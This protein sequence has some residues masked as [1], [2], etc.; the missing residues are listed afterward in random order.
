MAAD[1]LSPT[2]RTGNAAR[3][4]NVVAL[5]T[6]A[7]A[8]VRQPGGRAAGTYR[9]ANPW[10]GNDR[11]PV[12]GPSEAYQLARVE[13]D[14]AQYRYRL[15][16]A[17]S[18]RAR[19]TLPPDEAEKV[20]EEVQQFFDAYLEATAVLAETPAVTTGQL[21]SKVSTIGRIWLN[22]C[23]EKRYDNY[24]AAIARDAERLGV[25]NPLAGSKAGSRVDQ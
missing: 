7:P 3:H 20:R 11:P 14:I 25:K 15:A 23:G 10:P 4:S 5:P 6:A 18:A 21:H 19:L 9:K 17:L 1:P 8:P 16:G 24:R 13:A 22:A 12:P 2:K